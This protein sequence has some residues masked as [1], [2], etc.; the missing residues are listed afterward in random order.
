M[1]ERCQSPRATHER[2]VKGSRFCAPHGGLVRRE[3]LDKVGL[4]AVSAAV[5]GV[6]EE[7]KDM[8]ARWAEVSGKMKR[9]EAEI[10]KAIERAK[11]S[12]SDA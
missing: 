9:A 3:M 1:P 2:A 10:D 5:I 12:L 11:R 8:A 7:A 6:A 4:T